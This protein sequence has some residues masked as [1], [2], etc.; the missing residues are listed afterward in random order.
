LQHGDHVAVPALAQLAFAPVEQRV[1]SKEVPALPDARGPAAVEAGQW[2]AAPQ[3]QR[4]AQ[5]CRA[6]SVGSFA[7][8]R[9]VDQIREPVDVDLVAPDF[10]NVPAGCARH[11]RPA[12]AIGLRHDPTQVGDVNVQRTAGTVRRVVPHPVEQG[13]DGDRPPGVG[14]EDGEHRPPLRWAEVQTGACRGQ[15]QRAE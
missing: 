14:G 2:Y 15:L 11:P 5:Q 1:D 3:A 12:L 7:G 13:V 10:Q 6:L 8:L 4:L 9:P